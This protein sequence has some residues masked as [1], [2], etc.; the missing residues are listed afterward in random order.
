M[1][2]AE[3]AFDLHLPLVGH[4]C[5]IVLAPEGVCCRQSQR[6]MVSDDDSV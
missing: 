6:I 1:Q 5:T 2:L 3:N 4:Y